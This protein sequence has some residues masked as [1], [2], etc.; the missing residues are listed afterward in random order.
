MKWDA[1]KYNWNH[2]RAF[3]ATVEEGSLSAAARA[4]RVSQPTLGRQVSAL[5]QEIGV[6]LFER[7]GTGRSLTKSGQEL[8]HYARNMADAALEFSLAASGQSQLV[9]GTVCI[10]TG[11]LFA[12]HIMPPLIDRLLKQQ[13]GIEIELVASNESSDLKRR[14]ADIAIRANHA[15]QPDL[16]SIEVGRLSSRLYASTAY[17]DKAGRPK[18][19]KNIG[20]CRFIGFDDAGVYMQFLNGL[21]FELEERHF[22]VRAQSHLVQWAM[23]KQGLGIVT[24]LE[25]IADSDADMERLFP[26]IE[27]IITPMY[28]VAHKEVITSRR[29]SVVFDFL[30]TELMAFSG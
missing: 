18:N 4:L 23:A 10:S 24:A 21:G 16:I 7:T 8:V 17:L 26:D 2:L 11:E 1:T 14:E 27:P 28:L 29:V 12:A 30:K 25:T 6:A 9:E 3:I 15:S 5:E 22:P 13:P 20:N 19:A